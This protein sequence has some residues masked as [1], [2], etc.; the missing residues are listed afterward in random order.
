MKEAAGTYDT[1]KVEE[2]VRGFWREQEIYRKVRELRSPGTP[3]FFVD[4]PPYT[5]GNIH[6]GTAWNKIL[7]DSILR[8][9][10]LRGRHIIERAGY[11]MHGLPIEVKVEHNL[12][13]TSKKDIEEYGIGRFIEECRRFAQANMEV[14]SEQFR[15]L[16]VWLDFDHPYLTITEEYIE[17]AWW[18]LARA[19]EEGMLEQGHRVVNWCPRCETAIADSEVEYWDA[20]DPSLFVKFPVRG[21]DG[22]YLVIWTTT[23]WTLPANVAAAVHPLV[24]Y[25][26]VRAT[27]AG[28]EETLWVA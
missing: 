14:M 16:G 17:A 28:V 9:H 1:E 18:T 25:A 10:R 3:F 13:F 15:S 7:K 5:T 11:D 2:W 23:P 19:E 20:T 27:K 24:I 4:G 21:A 6:L 12:G 26:K 22:E 8:Y